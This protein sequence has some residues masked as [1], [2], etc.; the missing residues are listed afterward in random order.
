ML[1]NLL[2]TMIF[3]ELILLIYSY[4]FT[5]IFF[6]MVY[7]TTN[8]VRSLQNTRMQLY[9]VVLIEF[10]C[11]RYFIISYKS[12]FTDRTFTNTTWMI[13]SIFLATAVALAYSYHKKYKPIEFSGDNWDL[14]RALRDMENKQNSL[15]IHILSKIQD[16]DACSCTCSPKSTSQKKTS[17]RVFTHKKSR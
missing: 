11:D 10:L 17:P 15:L 7:L 12:Q 8:C 14:Q 9:V 2:T 4:I 16:L 1:F 3:G 13:R 6:T 5:A